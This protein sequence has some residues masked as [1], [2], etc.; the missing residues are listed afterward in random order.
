MS[1]AGRL[2]RI[3]MIVALAMPGPGMAMPRVMQLASSHATVAGS[4][5]HEHAGMAQSAS[6]NHDGMRGH[7]QHP[8]R[9]SSADC[10]CACGH[11]L[12]ALS[13]PDV[14]LP[15]VAA[16][17]HEILP[18]ARLHPDATLGHLIRPPIG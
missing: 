2:L 3:L 12:Q 5:C 6:S 11:L 15:V 16:R 4:A 9:C 18:S 13:A 1:F 14:V 17:A 8:E 10:H 7:T